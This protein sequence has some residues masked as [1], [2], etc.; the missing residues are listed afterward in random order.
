MK[1]EQSI[2]LALTEHEQLLFH[3]LSI[4]KFWS[5]QDSVKE[6]VVNKKTD[7]NALGSPTAWAL[8]R[9]ITLHAWQ[10]ECV[11]K[12]FEKR[13]GTV[14]VVTGAGKT[15]LA[16]AIAERMQWQRPELRVAIV[17]PTIVLQ[18]QWYQAII[19]NSNLPS[20][21]VGRL[22]GGYNDSF[23]GDIRILLC[24]LKSAAERLPRLVSKAGVG[25]SLLLIADECH[26]AGAPEM[27]RL[28]ATKRAYNLGLSATPER[29]DCLNE[30][31]DDEENSQ[32]NLSLLGR[33]LGPIV[34]SMTVH[35]AFE[36][37][38]LPEFEIHHYGLLLN[39]EE[40][41]GYD[42]LSR[43]LRDA[44]A[45]LREVGHQFGIHDQNITQRLQGLAKRED[46]LGAVARRC[47]LLSRDRKR[48]LYDAAT[49][50]EAV[51]WI[52]KKEFAEDSG[53][54]AILFHESIENVMNIYHVLLDDFPVSV[55]HSQLP[56]SLRANSIALFRQGLAQVLVSAR[57]LIEGFNV[58]DTDIGIIVASSTSVRQ[59][60]Q[61]IGRLLRKGKKR[62]KTAIVYVLYVRSSVD[63]VIYKKADW[64]K[65]LGAK[66]NRYFVWTRN[67]GAIEESQA[68]R[69]PLLD[70]S[71][72]CPEALA[73][74]DEYPGAYEGIEYSCDSAGNI[75]NSNR[76]LVKNPQNISDNI[77]RVKGAD[78]RFRVTKRNR[79]VL[80]LVPEDDR[81]VVKFAGQLDVPFTIQAEPISDLEAVSSRQ[82]NLGDA[83]PD[84]LVGLKPLT[85]YYKQSRGNFV[86]AR[87]EN[88][89]ERY[90]RTSNDAS[91]PVKGQD[92]L[93]LLKACAD[94]RKIYPQFNKM[95][96]T[97]ANHALY[98]KDG[99]Y[100]YLYSLDSGLEF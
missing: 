60:I 47:V 49:R 4:R 89:G 81:W 72:I 11:C 86:L 66:R 69:M 5:E 58:P 25:D 97:E 42:A 32:Y 77:R 1:K 87:K 17:V 84:E 20:S 14:K 68:P 95:L 15:I 88:R 79:Y 3:N 29:E 34:Y 57:S 91:D 37:G 80:V 30:S 6:S 19:E 50:L 2:T 7:S 90:A 24:V 94:L 46:R 56:E 76:Q 52:L 54:R 33:E 43:R 21:T 38:I 70:E 23:E 39:D 41:Q 44:T 63:E 61:T 9:G 53:V 85:L 22:G 48:L 71:S 64:S 67:E 16:L 18:N 82:F 8:T 73:V 78:G 62:D 10:E 12:W 51:Q 35:E 28:F 13:Q 83:F 96:L 27:S 26:R 36:Q 65:V 100:L 99:Q 31:L 55:D 45:E 93:E 75:F 59:R 40:R 98:L 74:G 92:A